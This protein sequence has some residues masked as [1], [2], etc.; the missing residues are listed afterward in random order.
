MCLQLLFMV[1]QQKHIFE[2]S[3][4]CY[5]PVVP[6]QGHDIAGNNDTKLHLLSFLLLSQYGQTALL[7]ASKKGH[8]N[9]VVKLLEAGAKSN[10]QANVRNLV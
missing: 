3:D 1:V 8:S 5:V 9:I 4:F 6:L 10:H 2:C 7:W